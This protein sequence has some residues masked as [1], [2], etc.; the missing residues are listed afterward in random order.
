MKTAINTRR[1]TISDDGIELIKR[2]EGFRSRP[3][4]DAVGV[5]TIGYGTTRYPDGTK[6]SMSD[7]ALSEY[8]AT[9]LLRT[10][11]DNHY[12]AGV[13]RLVSPETTQNQFDALVSFAYNVGV[14]ALKHSTLL[15]LHNQGRY[16]EAENEFI[17]WNH[18]GGRVLAGLTRRR[19]E[20]ARLYRSAS[21]NSAHLHP[22]H[23]AKKPAPKHRD[24]LDILRDTGV[25]EEKG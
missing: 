22:R 5:P 7:P 20:E 13:S 2:F 19:K 25:E 23:R 9:E 3:Y 4:L 16:Q 15:K 12:A 8:E 11:I 1:I 18:A 14:G 6:V 17:R 21:P 24:P 10:M